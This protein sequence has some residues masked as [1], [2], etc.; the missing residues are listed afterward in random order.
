MKQYSTKSLW[1]LAIRRF[2]RNKAA[3]AGGI[4]LLFVIVIAA[5]AGIL[6]PYSYY[7]MSSDPLLSPSMSHIMGTD[8]FGRDIFSRLVY[9]ARVSIMVGFLSQIVVFFVG[10]FVGGIAGFFGGSVDMILMRIADIQFTFPPILLALVLLGT[11]ISRS[12]MSI[13]IV[14]GLTAWPTMAR[15]IRSQVLAIRMNTFIEAALAYGATPQRI[16]IRHV[17]PNIMGP[18]TVQVTFG[19]ANAIMIEAFLSFIGLG[20]PPPTPSWGGMLSASFSWIRIY[21]RMTLLPAVALSSTLIA[22]N[23]LGD[24]VRDALDPRSERQMQP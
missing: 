13:V 6:A 3:L 10:L 8:E 4:Y 18:I 15:L 14:I 12:L 9:G 22:I 2:V 1:Y 7:E 17:L 5:G 24:G 23:L 11:I 20:T 21:P 19:V 16:L